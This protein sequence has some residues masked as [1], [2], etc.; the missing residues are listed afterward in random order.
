MH[1]GALE[2]LIDRNL[3]GISDAEDKSERKHFID[4]D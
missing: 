4:E 2:A 3:T 1:A